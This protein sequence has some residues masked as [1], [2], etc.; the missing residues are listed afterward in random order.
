MQQWPEQR[1]YF[2]HVYSDKSLNDTVVNLT[3]QSINEGSLEIPSTVQ[4]T[5]HVELEER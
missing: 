3:C 2:P 5:K 1:R 4:L